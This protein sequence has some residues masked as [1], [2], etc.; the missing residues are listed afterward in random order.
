MKFSCKIRGEA[1]VISLDEP[2]F[3]AAECSAFKQTLKTLVD[4]GGGLDYPRP[5]RGGVYG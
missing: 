2:R 4:Q 5:P 3:V 1:M